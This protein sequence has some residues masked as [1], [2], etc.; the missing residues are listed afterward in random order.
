MDQLLAYYERN[1]IND[2]PKRTNGTPDMRKRFNKRHLASLTLNVLQSK[3]AV[4]KPTAECPVCYETIEGGKGKVILGC[5][6][7]FCVECFTKFMHQK[8]TC[9][10]C[11]VPF[12]QRSFKELTHDQINDTVDAVMNMNVGRI[13]DEHSN[14]LID[15][16]QIIEYHLTHMNSINMRRTIDFVVDAIEH[17]TA[18]VAFNVRDFFEAQLFR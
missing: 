17:Q 6:H 7:T 2:F 1:R 16:S 4:S 11:R 5:N 9:P 15:I 10:L 12:M 8:N 14:E 13:D 18:M 3:P